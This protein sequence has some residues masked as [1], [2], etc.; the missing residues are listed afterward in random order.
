VGFRLRQ[1]Q[2]IYIGYLHR[3]PRAVSSNFGV[4]FIGLRTRKTSTNRE[5]LRPP[6]K[7][8]INHRSSCSIHFGSL[9]WQHRS[10]H[11]VE[12]NLIESVYRCTFD[13]TYCLHNQQLD[14][15][16]FCCLSVCESQT[17]NKLYPSWAIRRQLISWRRCFLTKP[18]LTLKSSNC[19]I[20]TSWVRYWHDI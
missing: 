3:H 6:N 2:V 15:G 8:L 4:Y 14:L 12:Q 10:S 19:L 13:L 11:I 5:T 17:S 16:L 18:K 9:C 7:T 20:L 1:V